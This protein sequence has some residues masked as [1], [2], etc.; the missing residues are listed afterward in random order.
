[1]VATRELENLSRINQ[2][3]PLAD[4]YQRGTDPH[5]M[6]MQG[7][8]K[9][10]VLGGV[11]AFLGNFADSIAANLSTNKRDNGLWILRFS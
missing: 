4:F 7:R 11:N 2:N 1:M 9:D 3:E 5:I 6:G 8:C 10:F